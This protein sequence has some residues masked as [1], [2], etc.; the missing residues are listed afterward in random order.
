MSSTVQGSELYSNGQNK[1]GLHPHRT[2]SPEK[3][4]GRKSKSKQITGITNFE[5]CH[6]KNVI[7]NN[8]GGPS[9]YRVI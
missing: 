9:F 4:T 1:N 2:Y 6:E 8:M 5:K 7:E 3:E